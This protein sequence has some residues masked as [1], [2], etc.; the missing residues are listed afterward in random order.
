MP[1][2][3]NIRHANSHSRM[4]NSGLNFDVLT[5]MNSNSRNNE[6]TI[7]DGLESPETNNYY[8]LFKLRNLCS[9]RGQG[10]MIIYNRTLRA[11]A[12]SSTNTGMRHVRHFIS[13]SK[14]LFSFHVYNT[15]HDWSF[16]HW[17]L[18]ASKS[19]L[20]RVVTPPRH[21]EQWGSVWLGKHNIYL[22]L[23][24]ICGSKSKYCHP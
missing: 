23:Y 21:L 11:D 3:H 7:S 2:E 8:G 12:H 15:V 17:H 20:V 1:E 19:V 18:S 13:S 5:L 6:R 9:N 16:W 22:P 24:S 10:Y 4:R 14:K